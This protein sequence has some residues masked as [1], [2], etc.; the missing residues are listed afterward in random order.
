M[1][2]LLFVMG[3]VSVGVGMTLFTGDDT[4]SDDDSAEPDP[5][6]DLTGT[7]SVDDLLMGGTGD[8]SL[9]GNSGDADM[10]LGGDGDDALT[11]EA[12]NTAT[13]GAGTDQY[14]VSVDRFWGDDEDPLVTSVTDFDPLTE[15]IVLHDAPASFEVGPLEGE[16]GIGLFTEDG[17]L[18]LALP[19]VTDLPDGALLFDRGYGPGWTGFEGSQ[20]LEVRFNE[21]GTVALVP[22]DPAVLLKDEAGDTSIDVSSNDAVVFAGDGDDTVTVTGEDADGL[23]GPELGEYYDR[24]DDAN[25]SGSVFVDAGAGD[26]SVIVDGG[27]VQ[28]NVAGDGSDMVQL[29]G[30]GDV[31]VTAGDGDTVIGSDD[32]L[33]TVV[34]LNGDA[35]LFEGGASDEHAYVLGD[36]TVNAGGGDDALIASDGAQSLSGGDGDDTIRANSEDSFP[37]NHTALAEHYIDASVDTLEGGAGDDALVLAHGDIATGGADTDHFTVFSEPGHAMGPAVITDLDPSIGESVRLSLDGGAVTFEGED[38]TDPSYD[39]TDRITVDETGGDSTILV[40]GE[41]ALLVAGQTGLAVG[42]QGVT[43]Y[44]DYE[45]GTVSYFDLDGNLVDPGDLDVLISVFHNYSNG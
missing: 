19:G 45:N 15:Q 43:T 23:L 38:A 32:A 31:L 29:T 41:A 25:W 30:V 44:A 34:D 10:L 17:E 7:R 26:D 3:L 40:D 13:G 33:Y 2:E 18:L 27:T 21:D 12:G 5:P 37:G 35:A 9:T 28:V 11:L 20:V 39:L 14:D 36:S 24:E 16:D 22:G 6:L 1:L 8:D 42:Y 4:A